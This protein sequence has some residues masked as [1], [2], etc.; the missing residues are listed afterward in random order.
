MLKTATTLALLVGLG[1]GPAGPASVEAQTRAPQVKSVRLYVFD[2]GVL[3]RGEPTA[4]NLTRE[5]VGVTDFSDACFLVVHPRG[6]LLWTWA[7]F[8][9]TSSNPAVS[10]SPCRT[11]PTRTEP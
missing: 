4:Y 2:C 9:T 7:S 3:K 1:V 8:P 6:T 10:S 5:Q 11:R